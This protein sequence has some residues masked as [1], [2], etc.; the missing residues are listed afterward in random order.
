MSSKCP[1]DLQVGHI[2]WN[3]A[4]F[5]GPACEQ[6]I[7]SARNL[8]GK[9]SGEQDQIFDEIK[10]MTS[11]PNKG[12]PAMRLCVYHPL[13][14]CETAVG[15]K[16][17]KCWCTHPSGLAASLNHR[18]A[19]AQYKTID[20]FSE[21]HVTH[22]VLA[23]LQADVP[24]VALTLA[25]HH[26]IVVYGYECNAVKK[27]V[28]L[29]IQ[30]PAWSLLSLT[31]ISLMKWYL[32]YLREVSFGAYEGKVV[33]VAEHHGF[34]IMPFAPIPKPVSDAA[35]V[36]PGDRIA[37]LARREARELGAQP[38][39]SAAFGG[40]ALQE[41]ALLVENLDNRTLDYFLVDFVK[42]DRLTGRMLLH[43]RTGEVLS[44]SGISQGDTGAGRR[45]SRP[46]DAPETLVWQA[47]DQSQT[48]LLP[49]YRVS[50][51]DGSTTYVRLDGERFKGPL[52]V[53]GAG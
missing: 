15:S 17:V 30:D 19:N 43:A 25:I 13:E 6:M 11:G 8:I 12:S 34:A 46:D 41:P 29:L 31:G 22:V 7:L 45:Q 50:E 44:V 51:A 18:I 5:C 20:H 35:V 48:D 1:V 38:R 16:V 26:W 21:S 52:T 32:T 10:N 23:N 27:V 3:M 28:R 14:V 39:W 24:V 2:P 47:C 9:S 37:E 4:G 36:L 40:A 53:T 33:V 42:G 49:F